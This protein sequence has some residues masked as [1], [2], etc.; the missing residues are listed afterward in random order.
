VSYRYRRH[1]ANTIA[2]SAERN[3]R[4][5]NALF[6]AYYA[7]VIDGIPANRFAPARATMGWRCFAKGFAVGQ[8]AALAPELLVRLHDELDAEDERS[9][10]RAGSQL[11][12]GLNVVG[13]L[14]GDFGLAEAARGLSRSCRVTGIEATFHDADVMLDSRQSYRAMDAYLSDDM[15]HRNTLLYLNPDQVAAGA[16]PG[17]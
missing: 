6:A 11:A 9:R 14:R 16:R 15:P 2:E 1:E 12:E 13:Y 17:R 7:S 3:L 8:V 5:A 4:E 10:R